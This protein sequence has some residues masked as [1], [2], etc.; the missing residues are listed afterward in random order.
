MSGHHHH[1]E[2]S[3]ENL[4]DAGFAVRGLIEK[5]G[6]HVRYILH[7]DLTAPATDARQG[8]WCD[9]ADA[10]AQRQLVGSGHAGV[11]WRKRDSGAREIL[12]RR[13]A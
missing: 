9:A 3:G 2:H 4:I 10:E 11:A 12:Y 7:R 5:Y 13:P 6:G 1:H 8:R